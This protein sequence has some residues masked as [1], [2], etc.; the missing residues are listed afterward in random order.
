MWLDDLRDVGLVVPYYSACK[1]HT[2]GFAAY[3]SRAD[4]VVTDCKIILRCEISLYHIAHFFIA[5]HYDVAHTAAFVGHV[6]A[7]AVF[8]LDVIK[9]PVPGVDVALISRTLCVAH[10]V[11]EPA[12]FHA[13]EYRSVFTRCRFVGV[14]KEHGVG[15]SVTHFFRADIVISFVGIYIKKDLCCIEYFIDRTE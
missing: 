14:R 12:R 11:V 7:A 6:L 5:A 13:V 4:H 3:H 8:S 1:Q 2:A 9:E 10:C 15:A